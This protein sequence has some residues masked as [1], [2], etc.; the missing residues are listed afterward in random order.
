MS[1]D[2]VFWNGLD[3]AD[4]ARIY[5]ALNEDEQLD[6]VAE[7]D[8]AVVEA[9]CARTFVGWHHERSVWTYR[10]DAEGNGP[11]FDLFVGPQMVCFRCYGLGADQLNMIIDTMNGLGYPLYDPQ[12]GE[13]FASP[14]GSGSSTAR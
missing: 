11:G 13:R 9:A 4:P 12:T 2:L 3:G 10:P 6:G 1:Y 8:S 7:V 5:L 14:S